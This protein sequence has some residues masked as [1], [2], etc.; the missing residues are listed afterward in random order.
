MG[1][2]TQEE[3]KNIERYVEEVGDGNFNKGFQICALKLLKDL[4]DK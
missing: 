4:V 2:V 1:I 3:K